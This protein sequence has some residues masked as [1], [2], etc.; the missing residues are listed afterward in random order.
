MDI[1]KLVNVYTKIRDKR[2]EIKR[3]YEAQDEKLK[4]DLEKLEAVML[5][6]LTTINAESVRTDAGTFYRQKDVIPSASDWD[7]LYAWIKQHDAFD[8]LERR[9][10]KTFV[11]EYMESNE[12][13]LP[14]GVSTFTR[15]VVRVRKN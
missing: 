2:S 14:P 5:R 8:A 4:A 7:T 13:E 3:A 6:H 9:I 1:N 12:G 15:Y 11:T 10:K